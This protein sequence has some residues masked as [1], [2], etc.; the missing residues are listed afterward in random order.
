MQDIWGSAATPSDERLHEKVRREVHQCHFALPL[1][2]KEAL[3]DKEYRKRGG[4][5]VFPTRLD[6]FIPGL[7]R[8]T[9]DLHES[10]RQEGRVS[11]PEARALA[12]EE[13]L[14]RLRWDDEDH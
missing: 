7:H 6:T 9:K 8:R 4:R 3:S 14:L 12:V 1:V 2:V 13:M 5:F 11:G 10:W